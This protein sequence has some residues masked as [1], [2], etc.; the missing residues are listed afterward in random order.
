MVLG[1]DQFADFLNW[2]NTSHSHSGIGYVTPFQRHSGQD[3][4]IFQNRNAVI[5]AAYR[6]NPERWGRRPLKR[7]ASSKTILNPAA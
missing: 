7:Y 6:Q 4:G 2:Y 3:H 1:E 5:D